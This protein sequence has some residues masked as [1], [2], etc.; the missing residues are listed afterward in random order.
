MKKTLLKTVWLYSIA[1]AA[2]LLVACGG[3]GAADKEKAAADSLAAL[4]SIAQLDSLKNLEDT[5][6]ANECLTVAGHCE[7]SCSTSIVDAHEITEATFNN[8]LV[9]GATGTTFT[10]ASMLS[11]IANLSCEDN[12]YVDIIENTRS[13]V[14]T[15]SAVQWNNPTTFPTNNSMLSPIFITYVFNEYT[16]ADN[17]E[18]FKAATVPGNVPT[19]IFKIKAGTATLYYGDMTGNYP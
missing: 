14:M 5:L 4:D 7:P 8:M 10:K 1:I 2:T 11:L 16:T 12:D 3:S 17:I 18:I 15:L 19:A 6:G 9:S 13:Q